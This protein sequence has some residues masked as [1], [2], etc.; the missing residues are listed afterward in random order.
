MLCCV[1]FCSVLLSGVVLCFMFYVLCYAGVCCDMM[2]RGV[3]CVVCV[4]LKELK[5]HIDNCLE[6]SRVG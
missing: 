3:F 1:V 5:N 2:C 4:V 6:R